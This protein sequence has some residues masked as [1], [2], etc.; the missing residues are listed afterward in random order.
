MFKDI[1]KL[2]CQTL[3]IPNYASRCIFSVS[4]LLG[5][6]LK[7]GQ[8]WGVQSYIRHIVYYSEFSTHAKEGTEFSVLT[9]LVM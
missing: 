3:Q 1:D 7:Y 6:H 2:V 9:I 4:K 8:W 5:T